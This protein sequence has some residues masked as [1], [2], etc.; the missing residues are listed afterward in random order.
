MAA[1]GCR[2]G[3]TA[4]TC[5]AATCNNNATTST[6]TTNN[7]NHNINDNNNNNNVYNAS[8]VGSSAGRHTGLASVRDANPRRRVSPFIYT[9]IP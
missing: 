8:N 7:N 5:S 4:T 1:V 3:L 9:Y 2:D 6:T